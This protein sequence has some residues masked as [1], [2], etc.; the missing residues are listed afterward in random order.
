M[1][2]FGLIVDRLGRKTGVVTTTVLLVLGII[3]SAA[4][5]GKTQTGMFWMLMSV[6]SF[7]RVFRTFTIS[8]SVSRG[9]TGVGAG[10]EYPVC[11]ASAIEVSNGTVTRKR[12]GLIMSCVGDLMADL[13]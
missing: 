11:G 8:T 1:L 13:G 2:G 3:L 6:H 5:S 9:L 4:A 7:N 12:R 10:G